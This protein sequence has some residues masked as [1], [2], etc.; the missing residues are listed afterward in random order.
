MEMST[1]Q[2]SKIKPSLQ[3][4]PLVSEAMADGLGISRL[5]DR[6]TDQVAL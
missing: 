6:L 2:Q 3:H 1:K 4:V 5:V